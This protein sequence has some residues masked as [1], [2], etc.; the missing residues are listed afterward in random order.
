M[1]EFGPFLPINRFRSKF[2]L[3]IC[4]KLP[5]PSGTWGGYGCPR[6]DPKLFHPHTHSNEGAAKYRPSLCTLGYLQPTDII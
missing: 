3:K 6:R 4:L 2:K 5:S 1:Y